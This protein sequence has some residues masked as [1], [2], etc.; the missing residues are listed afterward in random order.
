M[1]YV[2]LLVIHVVLSVL[3]PNQFIHYCCIH[4]SLMHSTDRFDYHECVFDHFRTLCVTSSHS[5]R[6]HYTYL[7]NNDEFQWEKHVS[8]IKTESHYDEILVSNIDSNAHKLIPCTVSDFS[9]I[10]CKCLLLPKN[11]KVTG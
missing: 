7:P 5:L 10:C 11:T 6:H 4:M 2:H 8:A 3:F 1:F 9:A